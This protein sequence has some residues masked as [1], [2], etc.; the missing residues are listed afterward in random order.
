MNENGSFGS[1]IYLISP[2]SSSSSSSLDGGGGSF[3][4]AV[5]YYYYYYQALPLILSMPM[6]TMLQ[7]IMTMTKLIMTAQP[8]WHA[9]RPPRWNISTGNKGLANTNCPPCRI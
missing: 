4:A 5:Y 2:S 1:E 8:L 7:A 9:V 3:D 6:T